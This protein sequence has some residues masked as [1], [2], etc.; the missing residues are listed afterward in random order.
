MNAIITGAS[1]GIGYDLTLEFAKDSAADILVIS[2]NEERLQELRADCDARVLPGNIRT[3]PYDL[4][5]PQPDKLTSAL[6]DW[7]Q[8]DLL[9]NNAGLLIN[10]PFADLTVEDWRRMFEVNFFGVVELIRACLPVL[11]RS[12]NAH[13]VNISSMGGFPGSAKF[14]GLTG[15][16]TS[17]GA[18]SNLTECLAEEFKDA[19]IAVNCLALGAV[20][21]EMLAEAFPGMEVPMSSQKMAGFIAYFARQGQHF[22]N[23]KVLPVSASTP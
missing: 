8:L 20:Q 3:L 5:K 23:G 7:S 22:F 10:K 18:L 17:K 19:G 6:A 15:Y 4:T 12:A 11:S 16:S 9:V 2:R 1:R 14:P 21:T 13:I